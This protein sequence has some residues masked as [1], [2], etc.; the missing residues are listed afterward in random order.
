MLGEARTGRGR[1]ENVAIVF[2]LPGQL[3]VC[4]CVC[5]CV[6]GGGGREGREEERGQKR[7]R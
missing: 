7:Y 3:G 4:V 5:V 2:A 6:S 1:I